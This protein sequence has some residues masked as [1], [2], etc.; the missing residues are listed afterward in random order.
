M[1]WTASL[2]KPWVVEAPNLVAYVTYTDGVSQTIPGVR[3]PGDSENGILNYVARE[4]IR[5]AAVDARIAAMVA[6][7]AAAKT[8][9]GPITLPDQT[10]QQTFNTANATLN[11]KLSAALSQKQIADATIIDGTIPAAVTAQQAALAA[12]Q[13]AK[14]AVAVVG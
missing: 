12:L 7:Q 10:A 11:T 1:T 6:A 14:Q 13:A 3:I 4:C 9:P 2:D 5:L 8:L